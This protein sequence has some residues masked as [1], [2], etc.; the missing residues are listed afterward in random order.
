MKGIREYR[1]SVHQTFLTL[2]RLQEKKT[3][4]YFRCSYIE[5]IQTLTFALV[6]TP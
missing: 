5:V 3:A 6:K 4:V 2:L 1:A